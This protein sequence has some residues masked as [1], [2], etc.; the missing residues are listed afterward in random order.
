MWKQRTEY[1]LSTWNT[2]TTKWKRLTIW[3]ETYYKWIERS[4]ITNNSSTTTWKHPCLR[5]STMNL[6][7]TRARSGRVMLEGWL[8]VGG[9]NVGR[10]VEEYELMGHFVGT[11]TFDW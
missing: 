7:R 8:G 2:E 9:G 11:S 10:S 5:S 1:K 4:E 3:L 6:W